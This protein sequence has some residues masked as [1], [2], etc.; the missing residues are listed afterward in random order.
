[1][2]LNSKDTH[3]YVA[4]NGDK[5]ERKKI[6]GFGKSEAFKAS[7]AQDVYVAGCDIH[8]GK[9]DV[10]DVVRGSVK[11][12]R[13]YL[14][15]TQKTKQTVTVKGGGHAIFDRC[16]FIGKSDRWDVVVG[17][18]TIY[19]AIQKNRPKSK[20]EIIKCKGVHDENKIKTRPI[21]ALVLHG[22]LIV[23]EVSDV[24]VIKV[25]QFL[26]KAYFSLMRLFISKERRMEARSNLINSPDVF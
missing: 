26:V 6:L 10:V 18:F 22:E 16:K 11:F 4:K 24:H 9:E 3:G 21:H 19:D 14:Y 13:T 2:S 17:D 15:P 7:N 5:L 1:M 8:G 25:P 20:V 23:D 12:I